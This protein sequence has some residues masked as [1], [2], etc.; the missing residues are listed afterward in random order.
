MFLIKGEKKG[1]KKSKEGKKKVKVRIEKQTQVQVDG[2]DLNGFI[3]LRY[4]VVAFR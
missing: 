1:K 4:A 3:V 2:D